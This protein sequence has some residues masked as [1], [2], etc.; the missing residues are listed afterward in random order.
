MFATKCGNKFATKCGRQQVD[1]GDLSTKNAQNCGV[2][3][4]GTIASRDWLARSTVKN[5][6]AASRRGRGCR[7][8][9]LVC[10]QNTV[11]SDGWLQSIFLVMDEGSPVA[12][13]TAR[14]ELKAYLRR[15][16][17]AFINPPVYTFWDN[18]GTPSI[19]TLSAALAE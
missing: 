15:W 12:A 5:G 2:L 13:F 14:P 16:L 10:H 7:R 1:I 9:E 4:I 3:K 8:S 6:S 11:K 17:D 19:M 18:R